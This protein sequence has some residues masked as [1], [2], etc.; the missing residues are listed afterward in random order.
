MKVLGG[1]SDPIA[2]R[3]Q[4][5]SDKR[6]FSDL[7]GIAKEAL[8]KGDAIYNKDD[9]IIYAKGPV[10]EGNIRAIVLENHGIA[11]ICFDQALFESIPTIEI[12][13]N[14]YHMDF[15]F[16]KGGTKQKCN[17]EYLYGSKD[18]CKVFI[19][20]VRNK[21]ECFEH[22]LSQKYLR[23]RFG[24][25]MEEDVIALNGENCAVFIV[26]PLAPLKGDAY[27]YENQCMFIYVCICLYMYIYMYTYKY[28]CIYIYIYIYICMYIYTYIYIFICTYIPYIYLHAYSYIDIYIYIHINVR[29]C[30]HFYNSIHYSF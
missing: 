1:L 3:T 16:M 13:F 22:K 12:I 20:N 11:D 18:Y 9:V 26:H 25:I 23:D 5:I 14:Y 15:T 17:L 24:S 8:I 7:L 2:S 10:W 4:N 27:V 6:V 30:I 29:I 19:N 28:I 21:E